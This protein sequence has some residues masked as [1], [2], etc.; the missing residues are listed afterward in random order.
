MKNEIALAVSLILALTLD[1]GLAIA[2]DKASD[3]AGQSAT[4][5]QIDANKDGYVSRDEASAVG[6]ATSPAM[7]FM[8]SDKNNDGRVSKDEYAATRTPSRASDGSENQASARDGSK[9]RRAVERGAAGPAV[10]KTKS[11]CATSNK[12]VFKP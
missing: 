12:Q 3:A 6:S 8:A 4:W 2:G 9:D 1:S 7:G 5:D 10:L 11:N